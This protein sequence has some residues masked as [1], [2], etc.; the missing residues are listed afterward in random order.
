[1]RWRKPKK[2]LVVRLHLNLIPPES[3]G[4]AVE[5]SMEGVLVGRWDGCYVLEHA[6]LLVSADSAQSLLGRQHVPV[7]RVFFMQELDQVEIGK[8]PPR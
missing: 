2:R 5:P 6:R 3:A 8:A 4:D 1:M 7:E